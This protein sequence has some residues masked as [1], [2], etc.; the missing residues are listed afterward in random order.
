MARG[1]VKLDSR[2]VRAVLESVEMHRT[3]QATAEQVADNVRAQNI[4]VGD[5][6]GGK[7]EDPMPVKVDMTTT[8]RAHA[9]VTITHPAGQAVQAKRG[10]LTRAAR[11]A[12]LD[13]KGSS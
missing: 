3:I 7:H 12:G 1:K 11:E 10:A 2:G 4:T 5:R 9:F 6:D 8:D 13:V